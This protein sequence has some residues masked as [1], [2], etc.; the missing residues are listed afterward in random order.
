MMRLLKKEKCAIENRGHLGALRHVLVR[1]QLFSF[2]QSEY[3]MTRWYDARKMSIPG[4][5]SIYSRFRYE[6]TCVPR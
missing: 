3:R 6:R 4:N 1:Y 5:K 2:G